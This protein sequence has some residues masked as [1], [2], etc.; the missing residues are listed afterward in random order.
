MT[1]SVLNY[2]AIKRVTD[3]KTWRCVNTFFIHYLNVSTRNIVFQKIIA[4]PLI[5]MEVKLKYAQKYI[6]VYKIINLQS[7]ENVEY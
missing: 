2:L 3:S 6:Y 7:L 1:L 5:E 4:L